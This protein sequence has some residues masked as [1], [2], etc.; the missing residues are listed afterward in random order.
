M[1]ET[2][3]LRDWQN[4]ALELFLEKKQIITEAATG[5]GKTF[6]AVNCINEVLKKQPNAKIL[7]VVP[8]LVI[9]KTWLQELYKYVSIEKI[10]FYY[11]E[12]KE[13]SQIT[14]TTYAS[15]SKINLPLFQFAIFDEIHNMYTPR[16]MKLAAYPFD[17]KLGLSATI[18]DEMFYRHWKLLELFNYNLFTYD[19][20][21]ALVDNVLNKFEFYNVKVSIKNTEILDEYVEIQK[22]IN[23]LL[24]AIGGFSV[25]LTLSIDNKNKLA[26]NSLFNKRNKL[27]FNCKEKFV[28]L[29]R[30]FAENKDKKIIIFNQ[31]NMMGRRIYLMCLSM[32][33]KCRVINS[34]LSMQDKKKYIEDYS[35]NKYNILITTKMFDEGYN[36]PAIDVAII[37]SGDSTNK[38]IQQRIGRTLRLKDTN[39]KIYQ[40]FIANTFEERYAEKRALLFKDLAIKY[41]TLEV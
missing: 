4:K 28:A 7:I 25:Y 39:S 20:K 24:S 23:S 2:N 19:I 29:R 37:F 41:E 38:Q 21:D 9:L 40:I 17:Y 14:L 15:V 35:N 22:S 3:E 27:I 12:I 30:I 36:L 1:K 26:L 8:K 33:L 5:T 34:V 10:G 16:L 11:G 13:Y 32:G 31:Y 18:K 6:F